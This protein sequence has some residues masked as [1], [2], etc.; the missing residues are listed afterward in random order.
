MSIE[1]PPSVGGGTC[2]APT[3]DW[4]ASLECCPPP[5]ENFLSMAGY[6]IVAITCMHSA[7]RDYYFFADWAISATTIAA[8]LAVVCIIL[9][10]C[11]FTLLKMYRNEINK[12]SLTSK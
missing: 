7:H 9:A 1:L 3:P 2:P 12:H 5:F 8:L 10:A 6:C 4:Q 11:L